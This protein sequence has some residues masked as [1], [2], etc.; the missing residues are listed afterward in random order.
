VEV[1][2]QIA[3]K[4][5]WFLSR[6]SNS[7]AVYPS[8]EDTVPA[9]ALVEHVQR[10][11]RH[12]AV[13]ELAVYLGDRRLPCRVF[14]YRLTEEVVEQRRRA[15]HETAR[16]KGRTPPPRLSQ[17]APVWVVSHEGPPRGLDGGDRGDHLSDTLANCTAVQAM[18][19]LITHSCAHRDTSRAYSMSALWTVDRD[20]HGDAG[21][22]VCLVVCHDGVTPRNQ[23]P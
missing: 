2:G 17:L 15:A 18:E 3:A 22:C 10:H 19:I 21:L 12:H 1:L 20:H 16:K 14:A 4:Q 23:L 7:V 8:A 9:L 5:A 11:A 13:V 6:L